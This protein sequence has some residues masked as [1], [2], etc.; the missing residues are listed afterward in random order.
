[1]TKDMR[2]HLGIRDAVEVEFRKN[3]IVLRNPEQVEEE[4][5]PAKGKKGKK[6]K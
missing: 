4:S 6:G 2:E 1:M 5:P 3:T